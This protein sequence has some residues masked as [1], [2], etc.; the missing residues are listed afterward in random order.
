MALLGI[1]GNMSLV[2]TEAFLFLCS[3]DRLANSPR[4]HAVF[5]HCVH[6]CHL[7]QDLR[8]LVRN[9][10]F[11]VSLSPFSHSTR[12]PTSRAV[13]QPNGFADFN[14]SQVNNLFDAQP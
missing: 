13:T 10:V 3:V 11:P 2:G 9:T 5:G 7:L 8:L 1:K 14:V 4:G 12:T 6:V